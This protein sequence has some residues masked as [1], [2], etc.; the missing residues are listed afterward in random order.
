MC[1]IFL[2]KRCE[3]TTFGNISSL[4]SGFLHVLRIFK[5]IYVFAI[6]FA[7]LKSE[8]SSGVPIVP[9]RQMLIL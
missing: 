5:E 2:C 1:T 8:P 6:F 9:E 7:I 3:R 4:N